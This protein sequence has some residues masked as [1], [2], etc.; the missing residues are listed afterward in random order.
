MLSSFFL[1]LTT[2]ITNN[3][4]EAQVAPGFHGEILGVKN[5]VTREM[6]ATR[7]KKKD[8]EREQERKRAGE[9]REKV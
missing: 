5:T 4:R 1:S 2:I 6:K 8:Q 9:E 7:E 3:N